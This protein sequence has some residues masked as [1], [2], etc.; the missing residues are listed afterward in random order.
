MPQ[1]FK[2]K[3]QKQAYVVFVGRTPGIYVTWAECQEQTNGVAYSRFKGYALYED[4]IK[5]WDEFEE[6]GNMD[7]NIGT[8]P[9]KRGLKK[10]SKPAAYVVYIG[11]KT[12]VFMTW[13][14]C[15]AQVAGYP[16]ARFRGF[17]TLDQA[18]RSWK[19]PS[20]FRNAP[21]PQNSPSQ[22]PAVDPAV[23]A[24]PNKLIGERARAMVD[25]FSGP[26]GSGSHMTT[27]SKGDCAWPACICT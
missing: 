26:D 5:A 4:A 20:W 19:T 12:G 2:P 15:N 23:R 17:Q 22:A 21:G 9:P 14:E 25:T 3:S 27:C 18:N 24:K 10:K 13:P 8:G 6:T 11:R 16:N 1:Q 7:I